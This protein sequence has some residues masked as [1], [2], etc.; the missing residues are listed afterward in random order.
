MG[1]YSDFIK[2]KS[3]GI[4]SDQRPC[5]NV[6]WYEIGL[7]AEAG[8]HLC[9]ERLNYLK[10]KKHDKMSPQIK[11]SFEANNLPSENRAMNT[12]LAFRARSHSTYN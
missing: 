12:V 4:Q 11:E 9:K 2:L 10:P 8:S 7:S 1:K 6:N 5:N 3:S